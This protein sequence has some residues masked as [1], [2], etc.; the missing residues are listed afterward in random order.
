MTYGPISYTLLQYED[1]PNWWL[2]A[3][4]Q[5][6]TTGKNMALDSAG[7]SAMAKAE[8]DS[9]GF[10][11]TS[12]D[13]RFNPY[14]DGA[15][16]LWLFPTAAEADADD[17]ANAI[18][19]ADNMTP[20]TN[21]SLTATAP[22][23]TLALAAAAITAADVGKTVSTIEHTTGYG[24]EGGNSYIVKSGTIVDDNGSL[25]QGTTDTSVYLEGL[26][27]DG[28]RVEHWGGKAGD[29]SVNNA[30]AIA[31]WLAWAKAQYVEP[32]FDLIGNHYYTQSPLTYEGNGKLING[33]VEYNGASNDLAIIDVGDFNGDTLTRGFSVKGVRAKI[34]LTTSNTGIVGIRLKGLVRSCVIDDCKA[35]VFGDVEGTKGHIGFQILANRIAASASAGAYENVIQNSTA[36]FANTSYKISTDGTEAEANADP[37]ANG[38]YIKQCFA[39]S[40]RQKAL[41]LSFGSQENICDIRADTFASQT[42]LGT[43]VIVV[44]VE[45]NYNEVDFVEE[46]GAVG[47]TQYSVRLGENAI[48]NNIEGSTQQVVTGFLDDSS[49]TEGQREKNIVRRAGSA[50]ISTRGR[51]EV[52]V[53]GYSV[54]ASGQAQAFQEAWICPGRAVITKIIAT[55][56]AAAPTGGDTRVYFAKNSSYNTTNRLTW[57]ASEANSVKSTNTDPSAGTDINANW[58]LDTDDLV[59]IAV[60]T[61]GGGGANVRWTMF[62]KFVE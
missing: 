20:A 61:P 7:T 30:A 38:N 57:T 19:F 17:T 6:T 40:G 46:I 31:S 33:V 10:P 5:G 60:D 3:Y 12:G 43:T 59:S 26:F 16:D 2:K 49:T 4:E 54:V 24:Y 11:I 36:L 37:Q 35:E 47:D 8:L 55:L 58:C 53:S 42:G 45:G 15:Y 50:L 51:A 21:A 32:V 27:S 48:Y 44:D 14:I 39:Y 52:S 18:Q 9:L 22:Y 13:V 34:G 23:A 25:I 41:D 29:S 1:Y 28:F 56:G 62:I